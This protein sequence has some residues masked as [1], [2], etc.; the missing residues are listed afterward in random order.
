[1][2]RR[3]QEQRSAQWKHSA[4]AGKGVGGHAAHSW[5]NV[6]CFSFLDCKLLEPVRREPYLSYV[7]RFQS[8]ALSL[9]QKI[10][11]IKD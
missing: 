4:G 10:S 11:L 2:G 7:L 5:K 9:I 1:M 8:L 6:K 3:A